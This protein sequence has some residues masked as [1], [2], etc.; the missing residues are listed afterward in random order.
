[1]QEHPDA[2]K[3]NY[4]AT[5]RLSEADLA[6]LRDFRRNAFSKPGEKSR[7]IAVQPSDSL[8]EKVD[9]WLKTVP[10]FRRYQVR[11]ACD[12]TDIPLMSRDEIAQQQVYLVPD[13]A[14]LERLMIYKTAG[15]T[16]HPLCVPSHPLSVASYQA[17]IDA[18]LESLGV[19]LD[20]KCGQTSGILI[21]AQK[22]TVTYATVLS[23]WNEGGF[24]K[25]NLDLSQWPRPDSPRRFLN[26]VRPKIL[27]GDPI[28]FAHLMDHVALDYAPQAIVTTAIQLSKKYRERLR[29]HFGCP[30]IDWYSLTETGPIGFA[31]ED[32]F[33]WL[34][35]DIFIEL[36]GDDGDPIHEPG[37]RGEIA[38]T[39]GRN[40]FVPLLRY[41]TGDFAVWQQ[42][43][44]ALRLSDLE[45]RAPVY[46][47][48]GKGGIVNSVDI[49]RVFRG[50]PVVQHRFRQDR[51][52]SC[53]ATV[54]FIDH[55]TTS[56][57]DQLRSQL[58]ELFDHS[59]TVAVAIDPNLGEN[60]VGEKVFPYKAEWRLEE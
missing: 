53:H 57:I 25:I 29:N 12:F 22:H 24:A 11:G 13:D 40:P 3:F 49:S 10:W 6:V 19:R 32:A 9:Y 20:H 14:N 59:C 46:Y 38:I 4:R 7:E 36:I 16:G 1:M 5:D 37:I 8:L 58:E 28:S 27:T 60:E 18:V 33:D 50:F 56:V 55:Q 52:L 23:Y 30:V 43:T 26:S 41:R 31:T 54:R 35:K 17:I 39:G 45:G 51:D 44:Y 2:P 48:D 42:G 15:T 47:R 34:L 21:G